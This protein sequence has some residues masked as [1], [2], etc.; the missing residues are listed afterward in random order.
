M[1]RH[2][3][4]SLILAL[5][6]ASAPLV[7]DAE[8]IERVGVVVSLT[9]NVSDEQARVIADELAE[10]LT[11]ELRVDVISGAETERRLPPN[12]I[13][14]DCVAKAGCLKDLGVRL[15]AQQ[16]LML[17]VLR[18]GT[19]LQVDPTW[20]DAPSGR[21]L[22]RDAIRI[23]PDQDRLEVF[24][25]AAPRLLPEVARR[26]AVAV[27]PPTP[28]T[29][30]DGETTVAVIPHERSD[31]LLPVYVA[32]GIAGA[33]LVGGVAFGLAASS[34]QGSLEDDMCDRVACDPSRVDAMENKALA[35]DVLYAGA[36]V[37][38]GVAVV[39]YFVMPELEDAPAVSVEPT[40]GGARATWGVR[41]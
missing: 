2:R 18:V 40:E 14:D 8:P 16:L 39:L 26:E 12:G 9:V 19:S 34:D 13:D 41:F 21:T 36:L 7:A 31:E 3:R 22:P 24:R 32:G 23:L 38:A 1:H 10:A 11:Q 4:H 29:G 5:A 25:A 33:L 17:V 15:E 6:L 37:S 35:A 30:V 20:V 28:P 27:E